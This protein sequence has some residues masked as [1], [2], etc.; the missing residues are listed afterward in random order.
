MV[1]AGLVFLGLLF[2]GPALAQSG[3][4]SDEQVSQMKTE[5][6]DALRSMKANRD[7]IAKLGDAVEKEGDYEKAVN[8]VQSAKQRV[9]T[10]IAVADRSKDALMIAITDGGQRDRAQHEYRKIAVARAKVQQLY[11]EADA[12]VGGGSS[13]EDDADVA[14]TGDEETEQD[15]TESVTE[16]IEV[17]GVDPPNTSPFE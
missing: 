4:L 17:V 15:E 5:V 13:A 11:A 14:V 10:L 1:Q 12:C 8:C 7:K 2:S 6:N 3:P 16:G 9:D